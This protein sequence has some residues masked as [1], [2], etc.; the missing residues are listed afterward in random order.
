MPKI[1]DET[2][3]KV[4]T[5]GYNIY[6]ASSILKIVHK[7][8]EQ[9]KRDYV[10]RDVPY[11]KNMVR[12]FQQNGKES[13]N[14]RVRK[15]IQAESSRVSRDKNKFMRMRL[16]EDNEKLKSIL[17]DRIERLVNVECYVNDFLVKNDQPS[18]DWRNGWNDD[19]CCDLYDSND[20]E[21]E[22]MDEAEAHDAVNE[23]SI[24]S[25]LHCDDQ[26]MI[27]FNE[28]DS[29]NENLTIYEIQG[30]GNDSGEDDTM[31]ASCM[32]QSQKLKI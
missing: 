11:N 10:K 25:D 27:D 1:A 18:I 19:A 8:E 3:S 5:S 28:T 22:S 24:M 29:D 13:C 23:S 7:L 16:D 9:Y 14:V 2:V 17:G 20:D 30:E 31:E 32:Q 12:R 15:N 4:S 6:D 21:Y 26:C